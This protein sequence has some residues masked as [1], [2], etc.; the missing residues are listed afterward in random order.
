MKVPVITI[1]GASGC[2]KGTLAQKLAYRLGWHFLDSGAIYR[3]LALYALENQVQFDDEVKLAGLTKNMPLRFM[4]SETGILNVFLGRQEI[5]AVL[6]TEETGGY[7]SQVARYPL[8]REALLDFQHHFAQAPGLVADG[9]DM[10]TVVFPEADVKI[11][12]CASA[13]VRAKRR[14]HQ[15][16]QLG[17]TAKISD[18]IME[19]KVRDERDRN[20]TVSPLAPAKEAFII[21]TSEMDAQAVFD[22]AW[23]YLHDKLGQTA[24]I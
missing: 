9:R 14:Q 4:S 15:L 19:I 12:L 13:E 21:D 11:F 22:K 18:L 17:I 24:K 7:A 5:S 16:S 3:A 8:V 23:N 1:D 10:G 20:R 6:R 2:G